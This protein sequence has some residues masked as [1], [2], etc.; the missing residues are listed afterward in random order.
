M[1]KTLKSLL[2]LAVGLVAYGLAV[3]FLLHNDMAIGRWLFG[4]FLVGH[5][6]V[7]V[8][9]AA[10]QPAARPATANGVDYPFDM[11]RS[12]PVSA[13]LDAGLVRILAVALASSIVLGFVLAGLAIVGL[14]VPAGWWQGLVVGSTFA[15]IVLLALAFSPGLLL[16]VAI[17]ALLLWVVFASSWVPVAAIAQRGGV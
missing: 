15:S 16:G 17:D 11:A 4:T 2:P 8:M 6:L 3:W 7:H 13:G 10:P 1:A 14:L 5:G 12:W 9:F